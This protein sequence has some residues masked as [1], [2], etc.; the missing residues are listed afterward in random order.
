MGFITD[1]C[2]N[3]EQEPRRA[4]LR[5]RAARPVPLAA[6]GTDAREEPTSGRAVLASGQ[7]GR[8]RF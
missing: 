4:P 1:S 6:A 7:R 8:G 3:C 2:R 5:G